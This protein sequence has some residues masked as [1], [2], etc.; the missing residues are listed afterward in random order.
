MGSS[1]SEPGFIVETKDYRLDFRFST[2]VEK[3]WQDNLPV[4]SEELFGK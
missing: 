2:L 3:V 4:V 1:I